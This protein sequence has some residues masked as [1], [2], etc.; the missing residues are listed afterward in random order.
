MKKLFLVMLVLVMLV[1]L[2]TAALPVQAGKGVGPPSGSPGWSH[3]SPGQG[4]S[5]PDGG[6]DR[7]II[8]RVI[9]VRPSR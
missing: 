9:F 7:Q 5:S 3:E 4:G 2:L 8:G 6:P 1:V